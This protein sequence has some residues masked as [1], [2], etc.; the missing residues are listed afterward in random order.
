MRR[1]STRLDALLRSMPSNTGVG[2]RVSV[3][4]GTMVSAVAALS[5]A[6]VGAP[7]DGVAE[8]QPVAA[9]NRPASASHSPHWRAIRVIIALLPFRSWVG[10]IG[11]RH[12]ACD[13]ITRRVFYRRSY[14]E[15]LRS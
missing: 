11:R 12:V 15:G 4:V 1:T 6:A 5:G 8:V 13:R 3:G 2:V 7:P 9:I 14:R 10:A